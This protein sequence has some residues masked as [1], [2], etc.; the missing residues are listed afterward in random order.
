VQDAAFVILLDA[1]RVLLVPDELTNA[2]PDHP[3]GR[4]DPSDPQQGTTDA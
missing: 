1:D 3:T 2:L 4:P